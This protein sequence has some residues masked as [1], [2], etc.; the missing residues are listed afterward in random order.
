MLRCTDRSCTYKY[1]LPDAAWQWTSTSEAYKYGY[2]G[3]R[4]TTV[5]TRLPSS[6]L[7][8]DEDNYVLVCC[9]GAIDR[10]DPHTPML[11]MKTTQQIGTK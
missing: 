2:L 6:R 7:F 4:V 5:G 10:D 1:P 11:Y 9:E 3:V 8:V